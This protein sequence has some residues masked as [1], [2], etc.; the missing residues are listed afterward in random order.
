MINGRDLARRKKVDTKDLIRS[1]PM[2]LGSPRLLP[3]L[4]WP[5]VRIGKFWWRSWDVISNLCDQGNVSVTF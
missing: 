1:T 4:F 3:M 2:R 5:W